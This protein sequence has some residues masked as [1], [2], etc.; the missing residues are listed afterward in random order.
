[1]VVFVVFVGGVG[2]AFINVLG[3]HPPHIATFL[4]HS[5]LYMVVVYY[6]FMC[7]VVPQADPGRP[8]RAGPGLHIVYQGSIDSHVAAARFAF[9]FAFVFAFSFASV[10]TFSFALSFVFGF[11]FSFVLGFTFTFACNFAALYLAC[12]LPV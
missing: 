6:C 10:F 5:L 9:R 12:A 2:V 11:V 1:M 8:A 4:C 7:C 3:R